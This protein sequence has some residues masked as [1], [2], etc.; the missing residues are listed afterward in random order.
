MATGDKAI[1]FAAPQDGVVY[2]RD[3]TDNRVLYSTDVKK[4]QVVGYDPDTQ[5]L[6]IDKSMTGDL[7]PGHNHQ[8]SI[9]FH[10]VGNPESAARAEAA[11]DLNAG[12]PTTRPSDMPVIHVPVGVQVEVQTQ[13]SAPK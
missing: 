10:G 8:H 7:I 2:L 13:P 4:G 12:R 6:A 3:D 11:A 5:Q 9:F 1:A